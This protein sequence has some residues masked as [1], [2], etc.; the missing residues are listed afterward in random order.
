MSVDKIEVDDDDAVCGITSQPP[1]LM[2]MMSCCKPKIALDSFMTFYYPRL[3]A[4]D[5]TSPTLPPS[6]TFHDVNLTGTVATASR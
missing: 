1:A 4:A 2:M 5:P 6:V 3:S